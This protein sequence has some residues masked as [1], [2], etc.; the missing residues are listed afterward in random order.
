MSEK[1]TSV[2]QPGRLEARKRAHWVAKAGLLAAGAILLM[3][4]E[5]VLPFMPTFLKFDFSEIVVLLAA[6]SMGPLTA[7]LIEL[8]KNLAHLPTTGTGGVGELANFVIGSAFVGTAGLIYR[9]MKSRRGAFIAMGSGTLVMTLFACVI[10]YFIM[11]PFYVE[12]VGFPLPA[13]IE[14]TQKVGNTLVTSLETLI[15]FVFVPF[16]LFKGLI[17]SLIVAIIYKRVSPILHR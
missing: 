3:Y 9:N 2:G 16:N 12:V 15:L 4:L 17:V 10:N 1:N 6:F 7:V 13:L 8:V 14:A 11:I 5:L